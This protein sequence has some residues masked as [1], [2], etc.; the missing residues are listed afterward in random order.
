MQCTHASYTGDSR[1]ISEFCVVGTSSKPL[2]SQH[3]IFFLDGEGFS[4]NSYGSSRI[5]ASDTHHP[6]KVSSKLGEVEDADMNRLLCFIAALSVAFGLSTLAHG[7]Y[8]ID[9]LDGEVTQH[10]V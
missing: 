6:A 4:S 2:P 1:R 5:K 9:S 8:A 3:K 7:Q 10:E